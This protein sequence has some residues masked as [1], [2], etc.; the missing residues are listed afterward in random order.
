MINRK[1]KALRIPELP[2]NGFHS[3]ISFCDILIYMYLFLVIKETN[4]DIDKSEIAHA[5]GGQK[6]LVEKL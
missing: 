4:K 1:K 3:S 5:I 6:C 2:K